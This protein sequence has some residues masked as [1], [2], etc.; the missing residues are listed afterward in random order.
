MGA[1]APVPLARMNDAEHEW[2]AEAV[3]FGL[4]P[5][6]RD[7]YFY[8]PEVR[9]AY[10]RPGEHEEEARMTADVMFCSW[11]PVREQCLAYALNNDC[12]NGIW[13]GTLPFERRSMRVHIHDKQRSIT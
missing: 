1:H 5:A 6:E 13:A 11:C 2:R 10:S 9:D 12:D 3:C 7:Q 4:D 8:P